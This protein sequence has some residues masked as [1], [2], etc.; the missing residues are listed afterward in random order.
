MKHSRSL[1]ELDQTADCE[2]RVHLLRG[3]AATSVGIVGRCARGEAV[4]TWSRVMSAI[5]ATVGEPEGVSTVVFDLLVER[6][7]SL[8]EVYR[9]DADPYGD[10]LPLAV[11][12]HAELGL[13]RSDASIEAL[14]T[15]GSPLE[16]YPDLESFETAARARFSVP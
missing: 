4:L 3:A 1:P 5:A 15:T 16:W 14:A 6:D 11:S 12:L 2:Y 7:A 8:L 9:L 13:G 10:A